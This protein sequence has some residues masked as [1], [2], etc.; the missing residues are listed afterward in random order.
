[1]S[2][3]EIG[4]V[5]PCHAPHHVPGEVAV[6]LATLIV[7]I[8]PHGL[9]V[10][11]ESVCTAPT[12][13]VFS[14]IPLIVPLVLKVLGFVHACVAGTSVFVAPKLPYQLTAVLVVSAV[15][16]KSAPAAVLIDKTHPLPPSVAFDAYIV[17]DGTVVDAPA[18]R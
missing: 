11:I 9:F 7:L 3:R 1:L 17:T 4:V 2:V 18:C 10:G 13:S 14:D 6:L 15:G 16:C 8:V 5:N 12:A